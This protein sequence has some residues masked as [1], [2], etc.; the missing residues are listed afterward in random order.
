MGLFGM[1]KP[2]QQSG[3]SSKVVSFLDLADDAYILA[4][5][6]RNIKP[7]APYADPAVCTAVLQE[8]LSGEDRFFGSSKLRKRQWEI[9]LQDGR[10]VQ[11]VKTTSHAPIDA[12]GGIKIPLGD[13][14][15]QAWDVRVD[16]KN[17]FKVIRVGRP[18]VDGNN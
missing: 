15:S 5:E 3:V 13:A 6:S 2:E 7:F 10:T 12:G 14:T 9:V 11:A 4:F 1:G 16:G 17:Q 18:V 8:I